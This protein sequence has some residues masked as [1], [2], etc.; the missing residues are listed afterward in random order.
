MDVTAQI[1]VCK[2][3]TQ[4]TQTSKDYHH[5]INRISPPDD[6]LSEEEGEKHWLYIWIQRE[7]LWND[8][9]DFSKLS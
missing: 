6:K 4:K 3:A 1:H 2:T 7:N 9:G 8:R 5:S